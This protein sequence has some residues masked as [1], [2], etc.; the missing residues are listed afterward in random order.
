MADKVVYV[1]YISLEIL[2]VSVNLQN[3]IGSYF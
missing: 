3:Y 1:L 2:E